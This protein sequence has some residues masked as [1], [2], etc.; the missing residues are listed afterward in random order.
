MKKNILFTF[1]LFCSITINAQN[2]SGQ[3]KGQFEDQSSSFMGWGGEKCDYVLELEANGTKVTGFSYTYFNEGGR[4]YYTICRLSGFIKK[5]SK[6]IE[7]RELERT[8]TNVPTNVRNCFQI[9]K[10][11]YFKKGNEETLEGSWIPAPDQ[12]GDCGMGTTV[13]NK[14]VLQVKKPVFNN[15]TARTDKPKVPETKVTIKPKPI[16]PPIVKNTPPPVKPKPIF[17][18]KEPTNTKPDI[19]SDK[20]VAPK[21]EIT[22]TNFEKRDNSLIKTIE[23]ENETFTV[24]FYDNGDID[25]DT[26]S[27]FFN[28]KLVEAHKRLTDKALTLTLAIDPNIIV[29]ELIMYAENLGSIPPNTAVMIVTDGGKRYE[30]RIASDLKKSGVIRFIHKPK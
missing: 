23:V 15:A 19:V 1:I 7:V 29:N 14:R 11:S 28:G 17:T 5:G 8:K 6:Y 22:T 13:L 4:R 9:H 12:E 21:K 18:P 16:A 26:I 25:G 2:F 24:D 27:V 30:V 20:P 10:L 3:W